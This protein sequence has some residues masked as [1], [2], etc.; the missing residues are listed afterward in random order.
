MLSKNRSYLIDYL[1][2]GGVAV[3]KVRVVPVFFDLV[4][5]LVEIDKC[6]TDLLDFL[7]GFHRWCLLFFYLL[8]P[9]MFLCTILLGRPPLR[10]LLLSI[11]TGHIPEADIRTSKRS[12]RPVPPPLHPPHALRSGSLRYACTRNYRCVPVCV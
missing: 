10:V 11:L 6:L 1:I 7:A 8:S 12:C 9:Q 3:P 4:N 5:L 2:D